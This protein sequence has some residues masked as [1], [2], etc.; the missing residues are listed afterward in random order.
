MKSE[1]DLVVLIIG[2]PSF[3]GRLAG[4]SLVFTL[5]D[6]AVADVSNGNFI[7]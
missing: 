1:D 3:L 7:F 6:T 5:L 2:A 4:L